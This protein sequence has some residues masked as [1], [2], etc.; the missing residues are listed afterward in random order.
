[1]PHSPVTFA[2]NGQPAC[3]PS[4]LMRLALGHRPVLDG[5]PVAV[6]ALAALVR[7]Q[8]VAQRIGTNGR[9]LS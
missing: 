2:D 6:L 1:M 8:I 7:M 5:D 9:A 3:V 4:I